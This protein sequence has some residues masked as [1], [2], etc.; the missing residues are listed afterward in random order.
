MDME[1]TNQENGITPEIENTIPPANKRKIITW[2]LAV[3]LVGLLGGG[4]YYYWTT[5]PQ[6]SLR[7]IAQAIKQHD[8]PAFEKHVDIDSVS[9]RAVDQFLAVSM[10]D[11]EEVQNDFGGMAQG[12]IEMFKPQLVKIIN[13]G[14]KNFVETGD[15]KSTDINDKSESVSVNELWNKADGKSLQVVGTKY[16]KKEGNL[17]IVGLE[18][19]APEYETNLVMDLKMRDM[20]GYWQLAELSNLGDI[21][22]ETTRMEKAKLDKQNQPIIEKMNQVLSFGNV[23][24]IKNAGNW[25]FDESIT[26]SIDSR[27]NGSAAINVIEAQLKVR[28]KDGKLIL[29]EKPTFQGNWTPGTTATLTWSKDINPFIGSDQVLYKTSADQLSIEI[30]PQLIKFADGSE[31]KLLDKLP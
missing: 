2:V 5:T 9:T 31:L 16:V 19:K 28:T 11:P 15:F 8:L 29:K 30:R 25:S 20:G 3:L 7:A 14:V 13:T 6:Y 24:I 10:N 21:I 12:M 4:G 26:L 23:N 18:L 1:Q 27:F 17:A 22:K